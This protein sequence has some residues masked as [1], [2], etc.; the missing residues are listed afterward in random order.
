MVDL[1]TMS[2][3]QRRDFA[4]RKNALISSGVSVDNAMKRLAQELYQSEMQYQQLL[5]RQGMRAMKRREFAAKHA[6]TS[7]T[8][9]GNHAAR[10]R[11]G[12][13]GSNMDEAAMYFNHH[14]IK[15]YRGERRNMARAIRR[16]KR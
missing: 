3:R 12:T 14:G 6:S 9:F 8:Q 2:N 10:Q 1:G 7:G 4:N 5:H 13:V 15:A 11:C 16:D